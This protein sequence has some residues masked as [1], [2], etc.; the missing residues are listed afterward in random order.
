ME[1]QPNRYHLDKVTCECGK[2]MAIWVDTGIGMYSGVAKCV[3]C[4]KMRYKVGERWLDR[5]EKWIAH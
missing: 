1:Y 2:P 4:G 3:F 5:G